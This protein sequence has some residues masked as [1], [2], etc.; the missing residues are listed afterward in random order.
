MNH[1]WLSCHADHRGFVIQPQVGFALVFVG[2]MA[3][4]AEV[5]QDRSNVAVEAR[6][7]RGARGPQQRDEPGQSEW[8]QMI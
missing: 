8:K 4:K 1:S 7:R 6:L 5:G 2:T 3:V